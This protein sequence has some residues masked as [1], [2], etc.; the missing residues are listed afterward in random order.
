[1]AIYYPE[2]FCSV[3]DKL[4]VK[5]DI[6]FN[7][8]HLTKDEV[9]IVENI[10]GYGIDLVSSKGIEFRLLNS[11]MSEFFNSPKESEKRIKLEINI[12]DV[13]NKST[14]YY[15]IIQELSGKSEEKNEISTLDIVTFIKDF[16]IKDVVTIPAGTKFHIAIENQFCNLYDV[17][18]KRKVLRMNQKE[19]EK[20]CQL[21][22][23]IAEVI[24]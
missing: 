18:T 16:E 15:K 22:G 23:Q 20:Y 6:L 19:I 21:E 13:I 3:G 10:I 2:L 4:I 9:C 1:M 12:M 14:V 24:Y 5:K 11:Q 17:N 7:D 8:F